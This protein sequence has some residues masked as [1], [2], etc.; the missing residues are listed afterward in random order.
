MKFLE[1]ISGHFLL[2]EISKYGI[3]NELQMYVGEEIAEKKKE[4]REILRSSECKP[5]ARRDSEE[6]E[7]FG[8]MTL[9]LLR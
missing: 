1:I 7:V 2:D 5:V 3:L 6:R 8:L 9:Q 4:W